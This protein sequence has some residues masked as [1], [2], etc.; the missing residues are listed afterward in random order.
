M[1]AAVYHAVGDVRVEDLPEPEPGPGQVKVKVAH[2]GVC[3]SDLHEYFYAPTF[4]PVDPHP[5][6]GVQIPS[7]MGHE[8]S[9]TVVATGSDDTGLVPGDRVAVRPTYVCG[10]CRACAAGHP[11]VCEL[12]AFHGASAPGGGLS[13]LTVVDAGMAHRLPDSVSLRLGA[14]VE[15]MAVAAHAV[16][17]VDPVPGDTVVVLGA[18]AIGIGIWFALR[19]RGIDNVVVSEPSPERRAAIVALGAVHVVDP[20]ECDPGELVSQVSE[21]RGAQA[22]F[23]AAGVGPAFAVGL[24]LLGPRGTLVVVGVHERPLEFNPTQLLMGEHA[25]IGSM[26]YTAEEFDQVIADMAR[27]VYDATGWVEHLPLSDVVH[28][29]E[30]LRSGRAMKYLI[31][32]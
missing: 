1:K 27:G 25:V 15:P 26:T 4:M 5:L 9:G 20:G 23:D 3:G 12:L 31:D 21:G 22:V 6:T 19:A 24:Q 28:A 32:L 18:G 14:L 13:E 2:N 29:F 17:R 7:I 11:N 10:L 8:F 16:N 30:Q